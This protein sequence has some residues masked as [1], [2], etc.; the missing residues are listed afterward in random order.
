LTPHAGPPLRAL[1]GAAFTD[2]SVFPPKVL[3]R[4]PVFVRR[5]DADGLAIAGIRMLPL[6]VPR[7][8]LPRR[9]APGPRV[10]V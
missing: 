4:Y 8:V 9:L 7:A 5:A 10:T 3:G 1:L 6:A 2:T